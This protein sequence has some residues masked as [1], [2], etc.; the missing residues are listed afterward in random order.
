VFSQR[1]LGGDVSSSNIS[2]IEKEQVDVPMTESEK[3]EE[4]EQHEWECEEEKEDQQASDDSDD[5][6]FDKQMSTKVVK[7]G[8]MNWKSPEKAVA[9]VSP[10][11]ASPAAIKPEPKKRGRPAKAAKI[12]V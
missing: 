5:S 7:G 3:D 11:Q 6:D 10:R 2:E 9:K 12:E 4:S 8:R 1:R